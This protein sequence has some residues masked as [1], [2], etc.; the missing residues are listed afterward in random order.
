M[1][2]RYIKIGI[3]L[4][5]IIAAIVYYLTQ[6]VP[7]MAQKAQKADQARINNLSTLKGSIQNYYHSNQKLPTKLSDLSDISDKNSLKDP[8]TG[9]MYGYNIADSVSYQLCATFKTKSDGSQNASKTTV[10]TI[11]PGIGGDISNK[12]PK[13]FYC[14][15][16]K[17]GYGPIQMT[18]GKPVLD[19]FPANLRALI[20]SSTASLNAKKSIECGKSGL[21]KGADAYTVDGKLLTIVNSQFWVVELTSL[22][23]NYSLVFDSNT[24]FT[25]KPQLSFEAGDCV[26][27]VIKSG[28]AKAS[29]ISLQ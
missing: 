28:E 10:S 3:V 20:S 21:K 19:T 7:L 16:L 15:N 6:I 1:I 26:T 23:Q 22:K 25:N 2:K 8:E 12:H 29:T 17:A 14:F 4:V 13:G 24:K 5:V 18:Y 27:A 9:K 11:P